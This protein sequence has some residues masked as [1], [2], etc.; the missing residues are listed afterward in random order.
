MKRISHE[1]GFTLAETIIAFAILSLFLSIYFQTF[2]VGFRSKSMSEGKAIALQLAQMKIAEMK[3]SGSLHAEETQGKFD[4]GYLWE[5]RTKPYETERVGG[6]R[7]GVQLL[8][9][10]VRVFRKDAMGKSRDEV[11]L[12]TLRAV[13]R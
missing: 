5:S 9:V 2:S 12:T 10:T 7:S 4:N 6:T 3:L 13:R 11:E 8:L 1:D